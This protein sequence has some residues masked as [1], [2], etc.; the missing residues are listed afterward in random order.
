MSGPFRDVDTGFDAG[1]LEL[2]RAEVENLCGHKFIGM[3]SHT[4]RDNFDEDLYLLLGF[5]IELATENVFDGKRLGSIQPLWF[6]TTPYLD[7]CANFQNFRRDRHILLQCRRSSAVHISGEHVR[8]PAS[9]EGISGCSIWK[10]NL[11]GAPA[12]RWT[13]AM[14]EV[15][16][17]ETGEYRP[18]EVLKGT[19]WDGVAALLFQMYPQLQGSLR[20][21]LPPST[22]L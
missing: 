13:P 11:V 7:E 12:D 6:A 17:I 1:I 19:A 2:S 4:N 20:L 16:G 10:T 5:P 15:I 9:L 21:V 14:A 8:L 3:T 18:A 22:R